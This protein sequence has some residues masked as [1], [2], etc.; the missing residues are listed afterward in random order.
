[1]AYAFVQ[2]NSAQQGSTPVTSLGV[3][4]TGV[5][6]GNLIAVWAKHEGAAVAMS[7]T[8][9]TTVLTGA[10][11][12]NHGN[13]DLSA[14][15]FYLLSA[16]SGNKTYT[17]SFA[18]GVSRAFVSLI[19]FECSN[20]G[21]TSS[22]D[23]EAGAAG[24]GSGNLDSGNFTTTASDGIA[25]GGYGEYSGETISNMRINAVAADASVTLSGA[26]FTAAWRKSF[27]S[28][29]T[30]SATAQLGTTQ[31]WIVRGIAFKGTASGGGSG[32]SVP[33]NVSSLVAVKR[34]ANF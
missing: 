25:F 14:Q 10:T 17:L 28:G 20:S 19:V 18:G 2:S 15:W 4:L 11:K 27:S 6:A 9:G 29:F 31:D 12:T 16:N 22:L 1:M 23:G 8:D 21:S 3:S 7:I 33:R 34:A 32:L 26:T 24:T 5:G 30:G 13:G